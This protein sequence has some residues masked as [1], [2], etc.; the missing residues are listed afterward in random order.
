[1]IGAILAPVI[2]VVVLFGMLL[3][4]CSNGVNV[5]VGSGYVYSEE[6]FQDYANDQ[7]KQEFGSSSAYEDNML[8]VFLVDEDYY[9]Y[10]Y[11]AWVGDHIA[12]DI[13]HLMGN[14]ETE[15]GRQMNNYINQTNYKY[16][17]DSDLASVMNAMTKAVEQLG[18]ENSFTCSEEHIQVQ[19]HMTNHTAIDLT[20]ETVNTALTAFTDAT[21]ISVVVVVEDAADVFASS[22]SSYTWSGLSTPVI[23]GIVVA[24]VAVI[25][26]VLVV[27]DRKKNNGDFD[28]N[29][30]DD[31]YR[32]F[33]N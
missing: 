8:L 28:S 23:V 27:K 16:S 19:S 2:I 17:L 15:L 10:Y 1:M 32:D 4:M 9:N 11:I 24:V 18:V 6:T 3:S 20:A 30:K 31:R 29:R 33:D 12:T 14:N 13:N 21:G 25:V 5:Q 7:Y 22:A 26:I